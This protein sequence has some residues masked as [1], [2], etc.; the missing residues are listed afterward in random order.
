MRGT[1]AHKGG[2]PGQ[3]ARHG[4]DREIIAPSAARSASAQALEDRCVRALDDEKQ[5]VRAS[6]GGDWDAFARLY[7]RHRP[8]LVRR[9][10]RVVGD[11]ALAEDVV[12]DTFLR[13][14][15]HIGRFDRSR[16]L[17]PW[18]S[19][20]ALRIALDER[21]ERDRVRV[22]VEP[23]EPRATDDDTFKAVAEGQRRREVARALATLP[24]RQRRALVLHVVDGK[25]YT[26]I[27]EAEG[28][29]VA[30]V[31]S[32]IFR[33]R[34]RLREACAGGNLPALILWPFTLVRRAASRAADAGA[35]F[36][37]G[38]VADGGHAAAGAALAVALA[39]G[40]PLAGDRARP[41]AGGARVKPPL[42]VTHVSRPETR[43]AAPAA[44]PAAPP[45]P[46]RVAAR[47]EAV[48]TG[49]APQ[50]SPSP[51]P[52]P[53]PGASAAET[54]GPPGSGRPSGGDVGEASNGGSDASAGPAAEG[55]RDPEA[56][57]R[58][59]SPGTN[60]TP[61]ERGDTA[62]SG[63]GAGNGDAAGRADGSGSGNSTGDGSAGS[64]DGAERGDSAGGDHSG[65]NGESGGSGAGADRSA[66]GTPSGASLLPWPHR[67]PP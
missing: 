54:A 65:A 29:S 27:A 9:V 18:L 32:L 10:V 35:A 47:P 6:Q 33:A 44:A 57:A 38:I 12:Q 24:D 14:H 30:S 17:L 19:T 28:T 22:G 67:P 53:P 7:A 40:G 16:E 63:D 1:P 31:E 4:R 39:V 36:G 13:A 43:R 11:R 61:P 59:D 64:G 55:P 60:D 49:P 45:A 58:S 15:A 56:K 66:P 42:V 51:S 23:P 20:I 41:F 25:R 52:T 62:G 21:R 2:E 8:R 5:L 26:E 37:S 46:A 48:P 50:P 34:S 3:P